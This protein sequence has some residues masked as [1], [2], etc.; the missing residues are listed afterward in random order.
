[1]C[2][3]GGSID[4]WVGMENKLSSS[5]DFNTPKIKQNE[6]KKENKN[7]NPFYSSFL[8]FNSDLPMTWMLPLPS[9][10]LFIAWQV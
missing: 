4:V 2:I 7:K 5:S 8:V 3:L 6:K 10:M 1:M 9:P